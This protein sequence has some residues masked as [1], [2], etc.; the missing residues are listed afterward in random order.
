MRVKTCFLGKG[1]IP[2]SGPT[3]AVERT[4]S[5]TVSVVVL[6]HNLTVHNHMTPA[7]RLGELIITS[8]RKTLTIVQL[9]LLEAAQ[10][11]VLSKQHVEGSV[12]VLEGVIADEDEGIEAF[13]YHT[14]LR[15]R[16]PTVVASRRDIWLLEPVP[17]SSAHGVQERGTVLAV[18][19]VLWAIGVEGSGGYI[20]LGRFD[21]AVSIAG[22]VG[23]VAGGFV[24]KTVVDE[25]ESKAW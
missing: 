13:E 14:D 25:S 4:A 9:P 2:N 20:D 15:R 18:E 16:V 21:G 22:E 12:N 6:S 10:S 19:R 11:H 3:I 1:G 24:S 5:V 8:T 23:E 17:A 7:L